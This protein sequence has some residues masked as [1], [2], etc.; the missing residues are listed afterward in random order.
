MITNP[1]I[2]V[3]IAILAG[4]ILWVLVE[5]YRMFGTE[6]RRA[7]TYGRDKPSTPEAKRAPTKRRS[8]SSSSGSSTAAMAGATSSAG[9]ASS[10]CSSSNGG[11]G[12]C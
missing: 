12:A 2:I 6:A 10:F 1:S 9:S 3:L 8:P 5:W 4:A 11:G 7:R